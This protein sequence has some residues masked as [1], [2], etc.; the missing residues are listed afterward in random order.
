MLFLLNSWL[1]HAFHHIY[2]F[3]VSN[4]FIQSSHE[5]RS[6]VES[7]FSLKVT[8]FGMEFKLYGGLSS[9]VSPDCL[10][11]KIESCKVSGQIL[12]CSGRVEN[13]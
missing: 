9:V 1:T 12:D 13:F 4:A 3:Y 10:T 2:S 8:V 5:Q 7:H 6:L 11:W